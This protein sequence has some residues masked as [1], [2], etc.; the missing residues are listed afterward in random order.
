MGKTGRIQKIS[1]RVRILA[2][3]VM[4]ILTSFVSIFVI[5]TQ[6]INK[7]TRT[8][9]E[10]AYENNVAT[11]TETIENILDS[12]KLLS[13]QIGFGINIAEDITELN[14]LKTEQFRKIQL[15]QSIMG[16]LRQ[17]TFANVNVGLVF[18]EYGGEVAVSNFNINKGLKL[19]D[20]D[21]LCRANELYFYG[22]KES[23]ASY[24]SGDVLCLIRKIDKLTPE[25]EDIYV[26]IETNY[27]TLE[28]LF[29]PKHG[30]RM[31]AFVNDRGEIC[32][33]NVPKLCPKGVIFS[34]CVK[35]GKMLDR[36]RYF[37]KRS[38][39]GFSVVEL[40]DMELE[41]E[42]Y[43]GEYYPVFISLFLFVGTVMLLAL[44]VWKSIYSPLRLFD[45]ELTHLLD[46]KRPYGEGHVITTGM[47]E[48]DSLLNRIEEMRNQIQ[49]MVQDIVYREEEKSRMKLERLRY[50]INP[51]FLMN[52]LNTIHWMAIMNGQQDIDKAVQALNRLL[53][54]N[55]DKDGYH[56]NIER[57]LSAMGEYLLLQKVR[58]CDLTYTIRKEPE[59]MEF[60]YPIPKF[61]LQPIIE[62]AI[63][64]GYRDDMHIEVAVLDENDMV[65]INISDDGLGIGEEQLK[66]IREYADNHAGRSADDEEYVVGIGLEYVIQSLESF[67]RKAGKQ[68]T[69]EINNRKPKGT[70]V[71]IRVPKIQKERENAEGIGC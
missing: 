64:H 2:L 22:P 38:E 28:K 52:T 47:Q 30:E 27:D 57:E 50:Q 68:G 71:K 34:E 33:S 41:R 32:W 10:T 18:F 35:D 54:Y 59:H 62:N 5:S 49:E 8:R 15:N 55:L 26:G 36:Y 9:I 43:I 20:N 16:K 24:N 67:Y 12:M 40:V 25:S 65:E 45:G 46:K 66:R 53:F 6:I 56:T 23:L 44:V 7:V 14:A 4:T 1:L 63:I 69:F 61:I 39:M 42:N 17:L 21:Y 70:M 29:S 48:Y 13:Q 37:L 60:D 58:L 51:H 19:D 11:L 3:F 31:L